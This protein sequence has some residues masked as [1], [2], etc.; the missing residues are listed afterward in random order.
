MRGRGKIISKKKRLRERK[1]KWGGDGGQRKME[2]A[3]R[4]RQRMKEKQNKRK[5]EKGRKLER[6]NR[7]KDGKARWKKKMKRTQLD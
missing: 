1:G 5:L 4:K 2:R 3:Y 6:M 7:I